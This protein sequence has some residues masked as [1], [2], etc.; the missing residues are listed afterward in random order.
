MSRFPAPVPLGRSDVMPGLCAKVAAFG[1]VVLCVIAAPR[2]GAAAE[3]KPA[4]APAD[5]PL[6]VAW[7][8]F[9]IGASATL[10]AWEDDDPAR[11]HGSR[12]T[13]KLVKKDADSVTIETT[14]ALN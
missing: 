10:V 13:Q 2:A 6:F 3:P 7:S 8:R 9:D 11:G 1:A 4:A 14:T 5:H 12:M